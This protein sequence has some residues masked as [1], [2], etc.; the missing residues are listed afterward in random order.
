MSSLLTTAVPN[1]STKNIL[2]KLL[3][4]QDLERG[5]MK[6]ILKKIMLGEISN[7]QVAAVL[8]ALRLKGESV[9]ELIGAT[10]V[11]RDLV[12]S[13]Q[14]IDENIIDLCG[15]GGDGGNTFNISTSAMFVAASA[16]AKVAKHGGRGV[17]SITG[18]ADLLEALGANI[19]LKSSDV[20][21]SIN[22]TG[23]GFM[24]APNHHPSMKNVAPIRKELG[25]R[26]IFNVLGPLTNPARAK[27]QLIGV[28]NKNLLQPIVSVLKELN[29]KHVL[30][31]HAEN[32]L[33]E[34]S[35]SGK[36]YYAE[37]N[38]GKITQGTLTP[39]KFGLMFSQNE[40]SMNDIKV[41]NIDQSKKMILQSLTEK[42]SSAAKIV[43]L[44]AGAAIY[45][46]DLV[47]NLSDGFTLAMSQIESGR[48]KKNLE[49][50]IEFTNSV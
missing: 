15:T 42:N 34:I 31:V 21:R 36:T 33:D 10:Q 38:D 24:F 4:S 23:V 16:G 22:E 43:A 8:I 39:E 3:N 32:G 1:N 12:D 30:V 18:S 41:K 47:D 13:V 49:N 37:L 14:L 7:V 6:F 11:M 2:N 46:A 45:V 48:A 26:T 40:I 20:I 35:L 17:S 5:E 29:S 50:F 28:F 25:T 9:D 19:N 44:N 27:K